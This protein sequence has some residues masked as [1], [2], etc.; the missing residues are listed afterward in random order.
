MK[1]L[2][3]LTSLIYLIFMISCTPKIVKPKL[4]DARTF[5]LESISTDV[6]Y[7]VTEENPIKVGGVKDGTG[8]M[9]E[10]RYLNGLAGPNGEKIDYFRRGS[11]C[12]FKTPNGLFGGGLLDL[13]AVFW[14]GSSDTLGIYINMY[15]FDDK[16]L[17]APKGLSIVSQNLKF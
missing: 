3:M 1:Q 4:L 5:K 12:N 9:N 14:E 15:D 7:G 16:P 17:L 11:C 2:L 10:R 6:T 13:Y 8:A